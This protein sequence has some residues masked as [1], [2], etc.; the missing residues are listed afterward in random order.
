[1][2]NGKSPQEACEIVINRIKKAHKDIKGLQVGFIALNKNGEE[3]AH[4]IYKGFNYALR[5]EKNEI[6]VVS[7]YEMDW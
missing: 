5:D 4:C 2:R 7:S 3:G 6:M 1:M